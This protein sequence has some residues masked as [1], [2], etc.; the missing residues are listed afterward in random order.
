[1]NFIE[2]TRDVL[3]RRPWLPAAV[4]FVFYGLVA[5][6][7]FVEIW[8]APANGGPERKLVEKVFRVKGKER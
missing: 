6:T 3:G 8:F 1:M 2:K 7:C 5:L 4:Y